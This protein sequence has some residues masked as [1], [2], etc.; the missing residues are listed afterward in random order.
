[1]SFNPMKLTSCSGFGSGFAIG[2]PRCT[3]QLILSVGQY[4]ITPLEKAVLDL[5]LNRDCEPYITL[6]EQLVHATVMTREFSGVGFFTHFALPK[7]AP[8]RRDVAD[9]VIQDVAAE[10]S[11]LAHGAS[12]ILFVRDGV[13]SCLEGVAS[14]G[15]WPSD[16]GGFKA[17]KLQ[18]RPTIR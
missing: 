13:L 6:R 7:S 4:M 2:F 16:I 14:V 1:M 12:F 11:G 10:I 17:Y 5:M 9:M 3:R 15:E 8:V 18:T